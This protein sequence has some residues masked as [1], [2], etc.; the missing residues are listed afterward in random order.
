M[1]VIFVLLFIKAVL[2]APVEPEG[3]VVPVMFVCVG[4]K[5]V[6]VVDTFVVVALVDGVG[7]TVLTFVDVGVKVGLVV[8][9]VVPVKLC[10]LVVLAVPVGDTVEI[11]LIVLFTVVELVMFPVNVGW[12]VLVVVFLLFA[13][14]I[15][16]IEPFSGIEV[17]TL[18][19][20]VF[21]ILV[22]VYGNV[23]LTS[24]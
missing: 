7:V 9:C 2:V 23:E 19:V 1:F 14:P 20:P 24:I 16:V 4:I 15:E 6:P 13:N 10:L 17:V 3:L 22:P 11:P 18:V 8:G 12:A 5:V 21:P